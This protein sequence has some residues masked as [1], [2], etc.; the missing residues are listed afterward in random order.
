MCEYYTQTHS[1]CNC[2]ISGRSIK[3][4]RLRHSAARC[5]WCPEMDIII[6][7]FF[8]SCECVCSLTYFVHEIPWSDFPSVRIHTKWKRVGGCTRLLPFRFCFNTLFTFTRTK[9]SLSRRCL[10]LRRFHRLC[11]FIHVTFSHC[12]CACLCVSV[13]ILFRSLVF[14]NTS[15]YHYSIY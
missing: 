13:C 7:F 5:C 14:A 2:L 4:K 10:Y 15:N 3:N 6:M 9:L 11:L 1:Q 12:L 8:L